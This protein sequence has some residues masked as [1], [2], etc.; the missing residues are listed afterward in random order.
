MHVPV[1]CLFWLVPHEPFHFDESLVAIDPLDEPSRDFLVQLPKPDFVVKDK[2]DRLDLLR[3]VVCER[4]LDE[5]G[6][7][8]IFDREGRQVCDV[9][10]DRG[11]HDVGV[12]LCAPLVAFD[13]VELD[14][15]K[16]GKV[17]LAV[18]HLVLLLQP[19]FYF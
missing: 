13:V 16:S 9:V 10:A 12:G 5:R 11:A 2:V 4:E 17:V 6:M 18:H 15:V 8:L 7:G 3:L 1:E 14:G 19:E